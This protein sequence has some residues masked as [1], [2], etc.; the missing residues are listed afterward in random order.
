MFAVQ[1]PLPQFFDLDGKPL[2]SGAVYFGVADQNP[3][4]TPITVYWDFD[5]TQPAAQPLPTLN[6]Y[7]VRS[8]TPAIVYAPA[9]YSI[10]TRNRKGQLVFYARDSAEFASSTSGST[11]DAIELDVDV[12]FDTNV[13]FNAVPTSKNG[14][15]IVDGTRALLIN[16]TDPRGNGVWMYSLSAATFVRPNDYMTGDVFTAIVYV[17]IGDSDSVYGGQIWAMTNALPVT[18]DT[19]ATTWEA[20][21]G[22]GL[23]LTGTALMGGFGPGVGPRVGTERRLAAADLP[24]VRLDPNDNLTA[25]PVSMIDALNAIGRIEWYLNQKLPFDQ[26]ASFN[27]IIARKTY[28]DCTEYSMYI[29]SMF[30]IPAGRTLVANGGGIGGPVTVYVDSI[31]ADVFNFTGSGSALVGIWNVVYLR[32]ATNGKVIKCLDVSNITVQDLNVTRGAY[33]LYA[34]STSAAMSNIRIGKLYMP[35]MTVYGAF[36]R[37]NSTAQPVTDIEIG[38]LSGTSSGGTAWCRIGKNTIDIRIKGG[39]VSGAT[40]AVLTDDD[41]VPAERPNTIEV[42]D[43]Y[44]ASCTGTAFDFQEVDGLYTSNTKAYAAALNGYRFTAG[45]VGRIRMFAPEARMSGQHGML[46]SCTA[47]KSCDVFGPHVATSSQSTANTYDG[48]HVDD[49]INHWHVWG[50]LSGQE[51]AEAAVQRYGLNIAGVVHTD[52]IADG[53]N[54]LGNSTGTAAITL[55]ATVIARNCAGYNATYA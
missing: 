52:I 23:M 54:L 51:A 41:G 55:A 5:G 26:S 3:E 28:I 20:S 35:G 21:D 14:V 8:G 50:G 16:Q 18:I 34:V 39:R 43:L 2:S 46:F 30:N 25:Y 4:T 10:T 6:G 15:D 22:T 24:V 38:N 13:N 11:G 48:I 12:L 7:I 42:K 32:P 27:D 36:L 53:L 17:V 45:A 9:D 29:D 31:T 19:Q 47:V 37:G 40:N 44:A 33:G 1:S 49:T